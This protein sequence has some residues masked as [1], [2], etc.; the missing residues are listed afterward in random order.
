MLRLV[1]TGEHAAG[2]LVELTDMTQPAASQHLRVLRHR[3]NCTVMR[4][5]G[6]Q[7]V[8]SEGLSE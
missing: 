4:R 7:D 1:I 8:L 6:K 3:D 5:Y 2:E